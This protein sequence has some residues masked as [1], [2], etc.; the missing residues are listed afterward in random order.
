MRPIKTLVTAVAAFTVAML[1]AL[2]LPATADA[3][4][5]DS[6]VYFPYGNGATYSCTGGPPFVFDPAW[7]GNCAVQQIGKPADLVCDDP[8]TITFVHDMHQFV[9]DASLCYSG[10][11]ASSI[12]PSTDLPAGHY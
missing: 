9:A 1:V 5:A 7:T 10:T 4:E 2:I 8:T 6:I 3:Q 11:D 12:N